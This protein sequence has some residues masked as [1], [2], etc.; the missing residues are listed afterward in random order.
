MVLMATACAGTNQASS[1]GSTG[2][3]ST[4]SQS[5]APVAGIYQGPAKA[6]VDY[7]A[8]GVTVTPPGTITPKVSWQ[9]AYDTCTAGKSVCLNGVDPT[10]TLALATSTAAGTAQ[11]D[12]SMTPLMKDTLVYVMTWTNEP[13]TRKG[14]PP[15]PSGAAT[16]TPLPCTLLAFVDANSGAALYGAEGP[17]VGS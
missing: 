8:A 4:A 9:A 2:P 17:Q 5:S 6:T 10:I 7:K 11:S 12:G 16:P 15:A 14:G 3:T 1:F 13:C